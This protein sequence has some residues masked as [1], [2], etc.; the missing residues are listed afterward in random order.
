MM[1]WKGHADCCSTE[2]T[3]SVAISLIRLQKLVFCQVLTLMAIGS[4]DHCL[5]LYEGS[6]PLSLLNYQYLEVL[7]WRD[8]KV[9]QIEPYQS[10]PRSLIQ[11]SKMQK[12]W[13]D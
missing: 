1:S 2:W 12:R 8:C 6:L 4:K 9:I 13:S 7:D 5:G 3:N 10:L 11:I